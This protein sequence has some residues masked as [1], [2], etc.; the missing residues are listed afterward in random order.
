MASKEKTFEVHITPH[1]DI[2]IDQIW[3]DLTFDNYTLNDATNEPP[4]KYFS[5]APCWGKKVTKFSIEI[6]SNTEIS[7]VI[8]HVYPYREGF[9]KYGVQ[10]GRI[11]S[12]AN[13]K[14]DYVRVMSNID[15]T[16]E[17]EKS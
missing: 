11:A 14:G 8:T 6:H 1:T 9:E 4:L 13:S 17:E 2:D 10:G 7:I 15:V 12:T 16:K 3:D 5:A